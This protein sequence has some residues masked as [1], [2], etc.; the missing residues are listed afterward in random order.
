MPD[1][2]LIQSSYSSTPTAAGHFFPFA[3]LATKDFFN[4]NKNV[5][6]ACISVAVQVGNS[7]AHIWGGDGGK[8]KKKK[9]QTDLLGRTKRT[10]KRW[11]KSE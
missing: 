5:L 10:K 6:K 9:R 7:E 4:D 2:K 11:K 1:D 3:E 8:K